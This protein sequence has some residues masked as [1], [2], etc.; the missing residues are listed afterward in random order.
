M[1]LN[2][3]ILAQTVFL[4]TYRVTNDSGPEMVRVHL[5]LDSSSG[6]LRWT[7]FFGPEGGLA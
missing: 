7:P 5:T 4:S 6:V 2:P 1:P 3:R